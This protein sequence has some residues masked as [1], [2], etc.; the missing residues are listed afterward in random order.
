LERENLENHNVIN[1][2]ETPLNPPEKLKVLWWSNG[3]HV[4]SGY[5]VQTNNVVFRLE[6]LGFDMRVSANF[7]QQGAA[8]D[9]NGVKQYANNGLSDYGEDDLKSVIDNW[10]PHVL[11]TLFDVWIGKFSRVFGEDW[12]SKLHN[13]WI[14]W[15]VPKDTEVFT[16]EGLLRI[17][18]AQN[19]KFV[20]GVD[21]WNP[22]KK[23]LCFEPYAKTVEIETD[24]AC[25]TLT[26]DNPVWTQRGWVQAQELYIGDLVYLYSGN[27]NEYLLEKI[28]TLRRQETNSRTMGLHCGDSGWRRINNSDYLPTKNAQG[29]HS[30]IAD[31][32][33]LQFRRSNICVAERTA[34]LPLCCKNK[35][36]HPKE[37]QQ[38]GNMLPKNRIQHEVCRF[39]SSSLDFEWDNTLSS[40]EENASGNNFTVYRTTANKGLQLSLRRGRFQDSNE[41]TGTKQQTWQRIRRIRKNDKSKVS[42]VYDL[43]TT[44]GNFYANNILIHNCP[45]DSEPVA[46]PVVDQ[47][48]KAYRAVAMSL[49]G[50]KELLKAGVKA[51]YI[52]HGCETDVFKPAADK[53][54][55]KVW[56]EK[57]S[58]PINPAN[59]ATINTSDF[60]VG[61]NA[62]NK[63]PTRKDYDRMLLS[64]KIFFDNCPEARKNTKLYLHTWPTFPGGTDIRGLSHQ[65]GIEQNVKFTHDYYMRCGLTSKD[66]AVQ[67][68]GFDVFMNL[69]RGEGFGVPILEAESC[70]VPA[71]A[72]DYTA[73]TELVQGHGWLIPPFA[74]EYHGGCKLRNGLNSLWA[75]PDEYKAAEALE[76]AYLHPKKV[77]KLGALS[78]MF[79]LGYDFDTKVLP[80][81]VELLG[82][83]Q[84]ELGMF[85]TAAKKDKAFEALFSQAIKEAA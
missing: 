14:A 12:L 55:S 68:G 19:A 67:Y 17:D 20:F 53:T 13:R 2:P 38:R 6:R 61:V 34:G 62:A 7:G 60:V 5:G 51:E 26:A 69:A 54:A 75:V 64:L 83:V 8:L 57:H 45:V 15:C 22:I 58:M 79:A 10:R 31:S 49:F 36:R 4:G 41:S 39:P 84:S 77:K 32:N 66:L 44:N 35:R 70:G 65:F 29:I 78:R 76:D 33:D 85:G 18:E 25:L 80:L 59:P 73:M 63:D 16:D 43:S 3:V 82:E 24:D 1:K 42:K 74:S 21:G 50:Q 48:G 52:P 71:I 9:Y 28:K 40:S 56:L 81:W 30:Y 11:I 37:T 47:A 23:W 27:P 72:T 46:E